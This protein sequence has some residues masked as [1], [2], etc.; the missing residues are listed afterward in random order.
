[1]RIR[2]VLT[3]TDFSPCADTATRNAIAL[4]EVW[5]AE[6][7]LLHASLL[8]QHDPNNPEKH[9]P[10][11]FETLASPEPYWDR[12]FKQK[13]G[14]IGQTS[15]KPVQIRG[16]TEVEAIRG[17][18]AENPVDLLVMGTHGRR[19][20]KRWLLGSVAEE[21]VRTA[22]CP[23]ITLKET[24]SESLAR[25]KKI[26]VPMDFS[27]SSRRALTMAREL[28]DKYGATLQLIHIVQE[29]YF[30]EMYA[31]KL[32]SDY[33]AD[34]EIRARDMMTR[35]LH[36]QH[37]MVPA[38]IVV[39]HGHPA[40]EIAKFTQT[41][42]TDLVVMAHQGHSGV[43]E[44]IMGGNTEHVIRAADCPVLTFND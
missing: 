27:D 36:D 11:T 42:K 9:L 13:M 35:M 17:Y 22:N 29:P 44:R 19:G 33:S 12:Q 24:W 43:P 41:E 38:E 1:M 30:Q 8:Y 26:A 15:C 31:K 14:R 32:S 23:V 2:T 25:V 16:I 3:P 37:G 40:A 39:A 6:V 28:A 18:L 34:Y 7:F 5:G 20:F 10:E 21:L 4:A